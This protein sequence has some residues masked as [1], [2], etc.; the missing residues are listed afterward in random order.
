MLF[1][2]KWNPFSIACTT[3]LIVTNKGVEQNVS[4]DW[5]TNLVKSDA[6]EKTTLHMSPICSSRE[7]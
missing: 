4:L 2:V 7:Q 1:F 5:S 6:V 3:E